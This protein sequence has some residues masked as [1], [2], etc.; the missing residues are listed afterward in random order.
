MSNKKWTQRYGPNEFSND[1][2]YDKQIY[3]F[4]NNIPF[5][6][7]DKFGGKVSYKRGLTNRNYWYQITSVY[8][9]KQNI[10]YRNINKWFNKN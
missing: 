2:L 4:E 1:E 7:S 9:I 8:P 3:E 10:K 5:D 6:Q